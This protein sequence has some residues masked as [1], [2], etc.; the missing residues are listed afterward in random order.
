MPFNYDIHGV[1]GLRILFQTTD[2][3]ANEGVPTDVLKMIEDIWNKP[4]LTNQKKPIGKPVIKEGYT[5]PR[6]LYDIVKRNVQYVLVVVQSV[7]NILFQIIG[8]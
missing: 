7:N 4:H 2:S 6:L 3:R 5:N 1:F 8:D